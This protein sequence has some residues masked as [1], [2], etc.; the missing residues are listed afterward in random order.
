MT[1]KTY[2][3]PI[4]QQRW[5]QSA[6]LFVVAVVITFVVAYFFIQATDNT[7][8]ILVINDGDCPEITFNLREGP[9]GRVI[10]VKL[11]PG[12]SE[13]VEVFPNLVYEY[14]LITE[15]DPDEDEGRCFDRETGSIEVPEGGTVTYRV[16]SVAEPTAT[17]TADP[18]SDVTAEA[19]LAQ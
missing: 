13:E 2:E 16:T 3:K 14:E 11:K 7:T 15:S 6:A 19:D 18:A 5:V 12:E 10:Q 4:W 1:R 9:G 8:R 17:P